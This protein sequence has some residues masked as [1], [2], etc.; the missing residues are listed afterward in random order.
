MIRL[1]LCC[2]LPILLATQGPGSTDIA[3]AFEQLQEQ[4]EPKT[5][6]EKRLL[7][8]EQVERLQSFVEKFSSQ[9]SLA[10]SPELLKARTRLVSF[11]LSLFDLDLARQ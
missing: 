6:I 11:C 3:R 4:L 8:R 1:L 7:R 5:S 9:E 10:S 2:W